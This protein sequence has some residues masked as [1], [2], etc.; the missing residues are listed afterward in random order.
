[1]TC[2]LCGSTRVVWDESLEYTKCP[3]CG[4]INCHVV[5]GDDEEEDDE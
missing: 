3:S 2:D 1:M 5:E 4:G